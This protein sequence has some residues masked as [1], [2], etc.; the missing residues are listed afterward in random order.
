MWDWESGVSVVVV[1]PPDN[2]QE[3]WARDLAWLGDAPRRV[4]WFPPATDATLAEFLSVPL[5]DIRGRRNVFVLVGADGL[6]VRLLTALVDARTCVLFVHSLA[7]LDRV[8]SRCAV[9]RVPGG[10][11]VGLLARLDA[12]DDR[13]C[14]DVLRRAEA[15]E[16][17]RG[18]LTK[19]FQSGVTLADF[20]RR[21]LELR[22]GSRRFEHLVRA[23]AAIQH[24]SLQDIHAVVHAEA[25]LTHL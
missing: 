15:G 3:R 1:G 7:G 16:P 2:G 13:A 19:L 10:D 25:F 8:V 5:R 14:E 6:R 24:R 20:F 18:G 11:N 17:V 12:S 22:R 23:A 9:I 4:A 21:A